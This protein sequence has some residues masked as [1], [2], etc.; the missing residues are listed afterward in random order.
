MNEFYDALTGAGRASVQDVALKYG[1]TLNPYYVRLLS[2]K[3]ASTTPYYVGLSSEMETFTH[4][5]KRIV[6]GA[7]TMPLS[8]HRVGAVHGLGEHRYTQARRPAAS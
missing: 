5:T 2:A 4:V 1:R 3:A 6:L 8:G 7:D